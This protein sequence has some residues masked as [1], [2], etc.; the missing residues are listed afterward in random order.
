MKVT[1]A[2]EQAFRVAK[3]YEISDEDYILMK[4]GILPAQISNDLNAEFYKDA[5]SSHIYPV[6]HDW[7][8]YDI[9]HDEEIIGWRTR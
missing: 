6:S 8:A 9:T 3:E 1:V 7:E 4:K 2:M 5:E